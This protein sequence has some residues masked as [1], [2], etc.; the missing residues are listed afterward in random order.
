MKKNIILAIALGLVSNGLFSQVGINTG[1]PQGTFH[2]DGAK[3]NPATGAP[4]NAQQ[5]N[6][7][8]VTSTGNVGIGTTS[9]NPS[10]ILDVNTNNLPANNKKG[11]LFPR[12][13]LTSRRDVTTV[14]NPANGLVVY[15]TASAG[16]NPDNVIKDTFYVFN[17]ASGKWL[18]LLD[19][20]AIPP[21]STRVSSILAFDTTGNTTTYLGSDLGSGNNIRQILFDKVNLN[22]S[23]IGNYN[24]STKEFTANKSGYYNFQIN[25]V[26]K[27]PF[28]GVARIGVSRP[29]TGAKPTTASNNTFSFLSQTYNDVTNN[30]PL[31]LLSTGMIYMNSGEKIIFLSRYIT[32]AT[33]TLDLESI[34]YRR[35]LVNSVSITYIAPEN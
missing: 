11:I 14:P 29:Y 12:V 20:T 4:N 15:N 22:N 18:R 30:Q 23:E 8:I 6:D 26:V 9:P 34:N 10:A 25:F 35:D 17:S 1:N 2:I 19:E 3:D 5:A 24:L 32:P 33:N 28:T 31:T 21:G 27:G 7:F 16:S 13:S